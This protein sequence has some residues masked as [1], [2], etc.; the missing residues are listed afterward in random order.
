MHAQDFAVLVLTVRTPAKAMPALLSETAS[1]RST[2]WGHEHASARAPTMSA[3]HS[4]LDLRPQMA[5]PPPEAAIGLRGGALGSGPS[6][7][8]TDSRIL[9]TLL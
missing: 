8:V 7:F 6:A 5:A 9:D 4:E 3:S 2:A 1:E